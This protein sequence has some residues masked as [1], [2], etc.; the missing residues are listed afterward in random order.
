[1]GIADTVRE[2]APD[3]IAHLKDLGVKSITM[4]TGDDP[5]TART[6]AEEVGINDVRAGLLP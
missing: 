5:I 4:L 6:I 2:A 1:M 3:T